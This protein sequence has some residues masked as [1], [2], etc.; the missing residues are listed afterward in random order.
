MITKIIVSAMLVGLCSCAMPSKVIIPL[1]LEQKTGFRYPS[2]KIS[3]VYTASA[4]DFATKYDARNVTELEK[5]KA[6][7]SG[8][9][10]EDLK[11]GQTIKQLVIDAIIQRL[12]EFP[13][14]S[15]DRA[16][17]V[18]IDTLN[19]PNAVV[20]MLLSGTKS[21][22]GKVEVLDAPDG[23]IMAA[24]KVDFIVQNSGGLGG[25]LLNA[26]SSRANVELSEGL[27]AD[28]VTQL[29]KPDPKIKLK[30]ND[31]SQSSAATVSTK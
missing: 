8:P 3:V 25:A 31:V 1:S 7:A 26:M 13:P 10:A 23:N 15:E 22:S 5:E 24:Y 9:T 17:R 21:I 16:L 14:G 29:R 18:S 28:I 6:S 20:H 2:D 27:G 4:I 30:R 11:E 12:G 19:I